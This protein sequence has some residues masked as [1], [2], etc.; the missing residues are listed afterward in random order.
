MSAYI[1]WESVG[2]DCS[3]GEEKFFGVEETDI[4]EL[5]S[6]LGVRGRSRDEQVEFDLSGV[7]VAVNGDIGSSSVDIA[8]VAVVAVAVVV[9]VVVVVVVVVVVIFAAVAA[10]IIVDVEVYQDL[11]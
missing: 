2:A 4:V 10:D 6:E 3:S 1:G 9:I 8:E 7:F 11:L 5:K